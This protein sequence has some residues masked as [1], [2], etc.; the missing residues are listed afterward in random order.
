MT[1][2]R[3]SSGIGGRPGGV[4][5]SGTTPKLQIAVEGVAPSM[6]LRGSLIDCSEPTSMPIACGTPRESRNDSDP[7][8]GTRACIRVRR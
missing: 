6:W 7:L 5:G 3:R 2:M 1:G 8:T 4:N